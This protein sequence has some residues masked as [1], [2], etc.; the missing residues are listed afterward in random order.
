MRS[1]AFI[2]PAS[3][4]LIAGV[5]AQSLT[6]H[7]AAAAGATIGTAA[8]KGLSNSITKIFGETDQKTA[9]AAK[10]ET[11]KPAKP[12]N[13]PLPGDPPSSR[14]ASPSSGGSAASFEVA[15]SPVPSQPRNRARR[16]APPQEE[17]AAAA[18][19]PVVAA[20]VVPEP[21]VKVPTAEEVASIKIGTSESDLLA[22]L[23]QPASR[24]IIPDDDG[25][26]REICQYWA[27]GKALGTIRLDNGQVVTVEARHDN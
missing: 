15:P 27:N 5:Q 16:P 23:G 7:A 14:Y 4:I 9:S 20:P 2:F 13:V 11:K 8:G 10:A 19:A 12:A 24:V 26:L 21:V 6:E 17:S 1:F 25:H 3:L 18:L 22:A